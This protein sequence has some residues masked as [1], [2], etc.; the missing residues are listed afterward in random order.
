M[1]LETSRVFGGFRLHQANGIVD[2][3]LGAPNLGYAQ[4]SWLIYGTAGYAYARL[5][6]E[7]S[8]S[9][10]VTSVNLSRDET[11]SGWAV[12][13]G[14]ELA[15]ARNWTARLEYLYI[16]LGRT[17]AALAIPG[18]PTISEDSRVTENLVRLGV[19]YR[20]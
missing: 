9:A 12:G 18:L 3:F 8:A 16:D 4:D 20:F 2:L 5:E 11:R 7:A 14:I 1:Q 6:T 17:N 13:G 10:G 19:N 15:F